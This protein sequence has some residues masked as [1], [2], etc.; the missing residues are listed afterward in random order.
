MSA[1]SVPNRQAALGEVTARSPE[2]P[3]NDGSGC[4]IQCCPPSAETYS[5]L[6]ALPTPSSPMHSAQTVCVSGATLV[7]GQVAAGGHGSWVTER[8]SC[9][10]PSR[11][12]I[13]RPSLIGSDAGSKRGLRSLSRAEYTTDQQ[14]AP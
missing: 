10:L 11:A 3:E 6:L 1:R 7:L 9:P 8:T 2:Y 14:W 4:R 12:V 5:H 13:G